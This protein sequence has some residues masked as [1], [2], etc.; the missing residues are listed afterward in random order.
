MTLRSTY[1]PSPDDYAERGDGK[2]GTLG[3]MKQGSGL[4]LTPCPPS[5]RCR[6]CSARVLDSGREV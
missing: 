2:P 3:T 5:K 4:A 1:R 6:I